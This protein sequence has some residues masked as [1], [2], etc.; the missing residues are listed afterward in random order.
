MFDP[1]TTGVV[2]DLT[3]LPIQNA[4]GRPVRRR[5][6]RAAALAPRYRLHAEVI[7]GHGRYRLSFAN[8]VQRA[9]QRAVRLPSDSPSKFMGTGAARSAGNGVR[10]RRLRIPTRRSPSA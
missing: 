1:M 4:G 3:R 7:N 6:G 5:G 9:A 8:G 2:E 10:T